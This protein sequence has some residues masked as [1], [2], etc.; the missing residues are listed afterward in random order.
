LGKVVE[1]VRHRRKR[2]VL[3]PALLSLLATVALEPPL[4]SEVTPLHIALL[5]LTA[6]LLSV[7]VLLPVAAILPLTQG[8]SISGRLLSLLTTDLI[9]CALEPRL[10]FVVTLLSPV[11]AP[12]LLPLTQ[13]R[14][15]AAGLLSLLTTDLVACA[16]EPRLL[17][18][19]NLLPKAT[20]ATR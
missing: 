15:I 20:L 2:R 18:V 11:G 9:T 6:P 12:T 3:I 8:R 4:L 13:S 17:S 5:S 1:V 10:L 14:P 7:G 16:L 19:V